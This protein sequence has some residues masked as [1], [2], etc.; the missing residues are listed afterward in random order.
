MHFRKDLATGNPSSASSAV[1]NMF[2]RDSLYVGVSAAQLAIAV[3]VTPILTRL[4]HPA[5]YGQIAIANAVSQLFFGFASLGLPV[6][7]QKWFAE[8]NGRQRA[9]GL[10]AVAIVISFLVSGAAVA[11]G[12]L[13]SPLVGFGSFGSLCILTVVWGAL[14]T[15]AT[16]LSA[17]LRSV[18]SLFGF[19]VV[20]L[21]ASVGIQASGILLAL[22]SSRTANSVLEGYVAAQTVGLCIAVY[23]VRPRWRGLRDTKDIR[24][25]F[26]FGIPL[27]PQQVASF[28][29]YSG[30]RLVIQRLRGAEQVGRY[31]VAYNLGALAMFLLVFMNQAWMPRIFAITDRSLQQSVLN[32][33]KTVVNRLLIPVTIGLSLGAPIV[34]RFWMPASY[35]PGKLVSVMVVI[36]ITSIPCADYLASS[37]VLLAEAR[38]QALAVAT[39]T[40]SVLNIVLNILLLPELGLTGSALAT[41]VTYLVLAGWSRVL[42]HRSGRTTAPMTVT[43]GLLVALTISVASTS[44]P[45]A[46]G[47]LLVRT[48]G[49]C[50][51]LAWLLLLLRT[52]GNDLTTSI[53]DRTGKRPSRAAVH[54]DGHVQ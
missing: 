12:V 5:G 46:T 48:V 45:L 43:A 16:A 8:P 20:S 29:L 17:F 54:G 52:V 40:C 19:A 53:A 47:W 30:D 37:R 6:S 23:L 36:A 34:G 35:N 44:A 10:A 32:Q 39:V 26:A 7:I 21:T 2:R 38:T 15:A 24:G 1:R 18:D 42:A 33:S 22:A 14:G 3:I 13:W 28:V 41:F 31:Q 11:S 27:V 50:L 25:A 49:A 4:L 9:R 51:C